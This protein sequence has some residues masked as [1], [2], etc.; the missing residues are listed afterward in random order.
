QSI[1]EAAAQYAQYDYVL[2]IVAGEEYAVYVEA[3]EGKAVLSE[4]YIY[5]ERNLPKLLKE[6]VKQALKSL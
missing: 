4:G 3:I 5:I 2:V 6:R 1:A